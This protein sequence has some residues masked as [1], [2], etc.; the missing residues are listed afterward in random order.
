MALDDAVDLV[1]YAFKHAKSGDIVQAPAAT[2]Q[3]LA[4][5]M[6]R[7]NAKNTEKLNIGTAW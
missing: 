5:A 2:I 6:M 7:L 4:N 1:L 3:T